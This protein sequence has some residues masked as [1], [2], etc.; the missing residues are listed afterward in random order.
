[1]KFVPCADNRMLDLNKTKNGRRVIMHTTMKGNAKVLRMTVKDP[2]VRLKCL[3]E[4]TLGEAI[5]A[6]M[7]PDKTNQIFRHFQEDWRPH[8]NQR[9]SY[10]LVTHSVFLNDTE[11]AVAMLKN[12]LVDDYGKEVLQG[13]SDGMRGLNNDIPTYGTEP[14]DE[15]DLEIEENEEDNLCPRRLNM[16]S[17]TWEW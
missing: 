2:D 15:F 9:K 1:M 14:D 8:V 4:K 6:I 5:L 13:F 16:N 12:V 10:S 17:T 3:K 11:K 7:T